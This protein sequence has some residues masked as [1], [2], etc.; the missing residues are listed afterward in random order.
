MEYELEEQDNVVDA[1]PSKHTSLTG[2]SA[3]RIMLVLAGM[4][5]VT[6]AGYIVEALQILLLPLIGGVC[7][8]VLIMEYQYRSLR[9]GLKSLGPDG[10]EASKRLG[11]MAGMI[12]VSVAAIIGLELYSIISWSSGN[13]RVIV[14]MVFF[15]TG[16]C[17]YSIYRFGQWLSSRFEGSLGQLGKYTEWYAGANLLWLVDIFIDPDSLS[18][19]AILTG[20]VFLIQIAIGY[21]AAR[22]LDSLLLMGDD[23]EE[24][25][26]IGTNTNEVTS[27]PSK[28]TSLTGR[29]ANRLALVGAGMIMIL[30]SVIIF[31]FIESK[32]LLVQSLIA[33]T[34]GLGYCGYIVWYQ[35]SSLR[36][37]LC[38]L[39]EKAKKS[40]ECMD[41]ML[42]A[43]GGSL[44][45]MLIITFAM[46][47]SSYSSEPQ[48]LV[49]SI[50][51]SLCSLVNSAL[52]IRFGESLKAQAMHLGKMIKMFGIL[53]VCGAIEPLM[54]LMSDEMLAASMIVLGVVG[55]TQMVVGYIAARELDRLLSNGCDSSVTTAPE[56][57]AC[58]E[59]APVVEETCETPVVEKQEVEQPASPQPTVEKEVAKAVV[60]NKPATGTPKFK[61]P[62]I[63]AAQKENS[64]KI[65]PKAWILIA[66][67]LLVGI[68]TGWFLGQSDNKFKSIER[69][70]I[71]F[72]DE[73]ETIEFEE[74]TTDE[75]EEPRQDKEQHH[76]TT[77][78]IVPITVEHYGLVD[79][80]TLEPQA[81]NSYRPE[82]LTDGNPA[83]AWV[84]G[85]NNN[86]TWRTYS[87]DGNPREISIRPD[88]NFEVVE[89]ELLNGYNKSDD[90]WKN[91]ARVSRLRVE[92]VKKGRSVSDTLYSGTISDTQ[93]W[94]TLKLEKTGHYDYYTLVIEDIYPGRKWNDTAISEVRF[95]GR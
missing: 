60:E 10:M 92:G 23:V 75:A 88:E 49:V 47:D 78:R 40:R 24:K 45:V 28:R 35:L 27:L 33:L 48:S 67:L 6:V 46:V 9:S 29:S 69:E 21:M 87:G 16:W 68:A 57:P 18:K 56:A 13:N 93:S 71:D 63:V 76:S 32:P 53:C 11:A 54:K 58:A 31:A 64:P 62:A 70:Q 2:C 86:Q 1:L 89:I 5:A 72:E 80:I 81:G 79:E 7:Y 95:V 44:V 83:T 25:P 52:I 73:S 59:S 15:S 50:I 94:Q 74:E 17:S 30:F 8:I 90:S 55:L 39:G 42:Y 22:E 61:E 51:S 65:G 34:G 12:F 43:I 84:I 19:Q 14:K 20:I 85:D 41:Q 66:G 82:N 38:S 3:N 4:I 37:G 77:T 36:K 91:N 26:T